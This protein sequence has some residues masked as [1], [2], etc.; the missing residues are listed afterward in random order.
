MIELTPPPMSRPE[1]CKGVI[2]EMIVC[3]EKMESYRFDNFVNERK[4]DGWLLMDAN[5]IDWGSFIEY[6]MVFER[7]K[8]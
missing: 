7:C 3:F 8:K 4:W 5:V 2:R 1:T 6:R